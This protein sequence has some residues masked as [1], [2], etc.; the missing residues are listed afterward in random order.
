MLLIIRELFWSPKIP[1]SVSEAD[2]FDLQIRGIDEGLNTY[3]ENDEIKGIKIDVINSLSISPAN[4]TMLVREGEL[5]RLALGQ[6]RE[7]NS[8]QPPTEEK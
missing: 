1:N 2:L 5:A 4:Q 3:G 7:N 6:H 8:P